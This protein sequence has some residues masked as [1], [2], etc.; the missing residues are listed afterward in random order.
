MMNENN[1]RVKRTY[2][3]VRIYKFDFIKSNIKVDD[4]L[5]KLFP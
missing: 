3:T 2:K 1:E 5:F 4:L